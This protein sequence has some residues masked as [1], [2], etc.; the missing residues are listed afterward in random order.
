MGEGGEGG[1]R[2]LPGWRPRGSHWASV[3]SRLG[4]GLG[5]NGRGGAGGPS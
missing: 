2:A 1:C 5:K 4:R 3:A